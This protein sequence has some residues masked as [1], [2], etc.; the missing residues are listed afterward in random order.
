MREDA[1]ARIR[2][3]GKAGGKHAIPVALA[4]ATSRRAWVVGML[5]LGSTYPAARAEWRA[6]SS[7]L[8]SPADVIQRR[9]QGEPKEAELSEAELMKRCRDEDPLVQ[10]AALPSLAERGSAA[11]KKLLGKTAIDSPFMRVRRIAAEGL[12][13]ADPAA[14]RETF[15]RSAR[16]GSVVRGADALYWAEL[17]AVPARGEVPQDPVA[18]ERSL[19]SL[20]RARASRDPRE[21]VAATRAAV[22]LSV[23]SGAPRGAVMEEALLG[24]L[25]EFRGA[26]IACA[27]LDAAL[28]APDPAD[29]EVFMALLAEDEL[30]PVIER[31]LERALLKTLMAATEADRGAAFVA[32]TRDLGGAGAPRGARLARIAGIV[33]DR[34]LAQDERAILLRAL[35]A[36]GNLDARAAAAKALGS[37]GRFGARSALAELAAEDVHE[38]VALQCVRVIAKHGQLV[39][40]DAD[41]EE[42]SDP[43]RALISAARSHPSSLVREEAAISLGRPGIHSDAAV[44]LAALA[45]GGEELGLRQVAAVALG[46]TRAPLAVAPLAGLLRDEE[47][48]VRAAAAEGLKQ[49]SSAACVAPLLDA[50]DDRNTQVLATVE[51]ALKRL[52]NRE[53]ISVDRRTWRDWWAKHGGRVRF[54]TW[55]EE[56]ARQERYGYKASDASLYRGLDVVVVPG[57]AD[58]I[59]GVLKRL[60]IQFRTAQA[61][62]LH[63]A[64]LHP[65]AILLVGCTGQIT[66]ADVEVVQW[67]V[68]TGG[69]LF[70]SCWALTY[71]VV[72]TSPAV[73]RMFPAPGSIVDNVFAMPT[74]AASTSPYLRGVFE[75]GVQP[76]YSLQ[77]AH[78]IHVVDP[79]RAEVLVD[80]PYAASRHGAGDLVAHFRLGHGVILD[81]ANHFQEQG[82]ASAPG[83]K[84]ALE[85]QAF[86]VNHMGLGLEELR[87][88]RDEAWWRS[89]SKAAQEIMDLSVFRILTN[90]VREK[91]L[92]S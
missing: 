35:L 89:P 33:G 90:F 82:F 81:S 43:V 50:L 66:P 72:P 92:N 87:R 20:K 10:L 29:L 62:K 64:S 4:N 1:E 13:K 88:T 48:S 8:R 34:S 70:T 76:Y 86:A 6:G 42:P 22:L 68:R 44:E 91:R 23:R 9:N 60:G 61:G 21:R 39:T 31:R 37:L 69:A 46:K 32:M 40:E 85:C 67:Y 5:L 19:R 54:R 58:H 45:R 55:A 26:E 71:T 27:V 12:A 51:Q 83:L 11:A 80:S 41:A 57:R 17:F 78:L 63:T 77:G 7:A 49:I 2:R 38:R 15:L 56:R 30:M 65:D 75:E 84:G 28:K 47:W 74:A 24:N 53:G 59:E 3:S 25:K 18:I 52:S 16:A 36:N 73:I 14:A 79:E